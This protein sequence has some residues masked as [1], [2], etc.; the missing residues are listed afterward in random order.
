MGSQR[1]AGSGVREVLSAVRQLVRALRVGH[2]EAPRR[3]GLSAAQLF[4]LHA[5]D[6]E[7]GLSLNQL[8]AATATDQSSVSVVV[9]RLVGGGQ[10]RRRTS[11]RDR[12]RLELSLTP[13]GRA[14]LRRA[15]ERLV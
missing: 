11:A 8:A 13:K 15:P 14:S 7:A 9:A 4:V 10:V 12:R 5:L 1:I 2:L 6:G 3:T